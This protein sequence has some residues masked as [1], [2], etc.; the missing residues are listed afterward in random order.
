MNKKEL[1]DLKKRLENAEFNNSEED[2][3]VS[4]EEKEK[5]YRTEKNE[6][7]YESKDQKKNII[8][9]ALGACVVILLIVLFIFLLGGKSSDNTANSDSESKNSE[10]SNSESEKDNKEQADNDK[11][12]DEKDYNYSDGKVF[13]NKYVLV[14]SNDNKKE[15][16]T[17]LDGDI[18]LNLPSA[19]QFYEGTDNTLYAVN[20]NFTEDDS[21]SVKRIKDNIVSEIINEKADG[22]LFGKE[23]ENILGVYK[24][25][26]TNDT[27]YIFDGNTFK[28]I[29][30]DYYG[31]YAD[32]NS[33]K[34]N[35]YI[36]NNRYIITFEAKGED[37]S[38]YGIYDLKNNKQVITGSYDKIEYLFGDIFVA[39]KNNKSGVINIDNKTLLDFKYDLVTYSNG[40][41][42]VGLN[43]K[44]NV[45]D[46]NF[47]NLNKEIEIPN[48]NK[49]TYNP[50][51]GAINPFDLI[52]F[53]NYVILRI[54]YLPGATSN[55]I[56]VDQNANVT[57][58]GKGYVGFLGDY[59]IKSNEDD[60]YINM[61]DSS[62]TI[63]HKI[64]VETKAI[65]LDKVYLFLN[66]T[67]VINRTKLY[68]LNTD[69]SKG[70]TSWY[71]RVSQEFDVR[72]DFKGETGTLTISS[73]DQVLKKLENVSVNEFLKADNNGITL[74]KNYFIYN[75]GGT[76]ILKRLE[77]NNS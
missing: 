25:N 59:L 66:N 7:L 73:N 30:L 23:K 56:A 15:V 76:V 12:I 31:A 45:F 48:L 2:L 29:N 40:L 21:Y 47:K 77:S 58:L 20:L 64:D 5:K 70:T 44:L 46:K 52:A 75:A 34:E 43:G 49:F 27:Y 50:C 6:E 51:C 72:I 19:W 65:K 74:T 39:V 17:N 42:F 26:S 4:N 35:K 13:F 36:Y 71:R 9:F 16:V 62:L 57:E 61:Y 18:I 28:T 41:Y 32:N 60:T 67:L 11:I 8:I 24:K 10:K 1:D 14:P 69:S 68:N 38:N 63:K 37:F 53:K 33:T 54:G 3:R 55:Y 22:L